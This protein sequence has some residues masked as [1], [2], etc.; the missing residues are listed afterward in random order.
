MARNAFSQGKGNAK[1]TTL[2]QILGPIQQIINYKLQ[3]FHNPLTNTLSI[4]RL[5]KWDLLKLTKLFT[6]SD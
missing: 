6:L 5:G 3:L 1:Y 4:V 2:S